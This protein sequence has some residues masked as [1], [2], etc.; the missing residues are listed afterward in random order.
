[1]IRMSQK[2][3]GRSVVGASHIRSGIVCQDSFGVLKLSDGVYAL[4]VADGHGSSSC[5]YSKEGSDRACRAFLETMKGLYENYNLNLGTLAT[6]LNREG[7]T[8]IAKEICMKWQDKVKRAHRRAHREMP[9]TDDGRIDTSKLIKQ[10]GTTLIGALVT[11][12]YLFAL[13]IGDGDISYI[14]GDGVHAVLESDKILGVE[15]HSLSR[16]NA[17]EKAISAIHTFDFIHSTSALMLSTDGFANSYVG[18]AGYETACKDYFDMLCQYGA[19]AVEDNLKDWLTETSAE[20]CGD[21]VTVMLCF[22]DNRTESENGG[23][24]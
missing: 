10:Y 21:D 11:P 16:N 3:I 19:Q 8:A 15:T 7:D 17:W 5:P 14:D 6:L 23:N 13:Q 22:T 4:A 12:D 1:M 24:V 18:E 20:G 2:I 9:K